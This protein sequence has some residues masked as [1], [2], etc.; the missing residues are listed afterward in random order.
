MPKLKSLLASFLVLAFSF[1][2]AFAASVPLSDIDNHNYQSAIEYLYGKNVIKGYN[3]GTFRPDNSV[4]RAELLKILVSG[5]GYSPSS[6]KY[7]SCFPD[8]K[9]DWYAPYVCFAKEK[10]WVN[11]YSDGT[12]RPDQAVNKVE[13]IKML[14]HSQGFPVLEVNPVGSS[15]YSDVDL[16]Q[17][18]GSFIYLAESMK[19]I[20]MGGSYYNPGAQIT[21]GEIS[22]NIY[23]A[24]LILE[25]AVGSFDEVDLTP[26]EIV[27]NSTDQNDPVVEPVD[28]QTAFDAPLLAVSSSKPTSILLKFTAPVQ[29][30]GSTL[31]SYVLEY[32]TENDLE[33]KSLDYSVEYYNAKEKSDGGITFESKASTR[34]NF[35]VKAINVDGKSSSYSAVQTLTTAAPLEPGS[36]TISI[37][38]QTYWDLTLNIKLPIY[39]GDSALKSIW[40]YYVNPNI[41]EQSGETSIEGNNIVGSWTVKYPLN[42]KL[43]DT[44]LPTYKYEFWVSNKNGYKS[45]KAA[46]NVTGLSANPS[47]PTVTVK[48]VSKNSID[49]E[50]KAPEYTGSSALSFYSYSLDAYT[51][52]GL[53]MLG[54]EV[55]KTFFETE[56]NNVFSNTGLAPNT[57]YTYSFWVKNK[58]DKTSEKVTKTVTTSS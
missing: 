30:G 43:T 50:V 14:V 17:W 31:K 25:Q 54:G 3:D 39:T 12:F 33:Y 58:H 16:K 9:K 15:Q 48:S 21:R 40:E 53:Y 56:M 44:T 36:P 23:R 11:G 10:G 26:I 20:G 37:V 24:M 27:D 52:E 32:K 51:T 28:N 57:T 1:N 34:Y 55:S 29:T 6:S 35:R 19:I 38:T 42:P 47:K 7:N 2:I 45:A 5:A 4:N 49:F 46:L 41:G 8:V 13:A 22:D 18:Y